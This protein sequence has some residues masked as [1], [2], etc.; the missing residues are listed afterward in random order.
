MAHDPGMR[1]RSQGPTG[2]GP[3]GERPAPSE[4]LILTS[5]LS[6]LGTSSLP[7]ANH[8][9]GEALKIRNF[10]PLRLLAPSSVFI[11]Y[12]FLP[13]VIVFSEV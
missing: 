3:V 10:S 1:R 12:P 6:L 9:Q 2:A 5:C 7:P 8:S 13:V 4:G 11:V